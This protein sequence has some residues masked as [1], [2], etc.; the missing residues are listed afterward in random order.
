MKRYYFSKKYEVSKTE[1]VAQIPKG[2]KETF[3]YHSGANYVQVD[4]DK[5]IREDSSLLPAGAQ[6][7][8]SVNVATVSLLG[9]DDTTVFIF[10][11][12]NTKQ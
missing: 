3:V 5:S 4:F 1:V 11:L 6:I 8:I 2:N 7:D 12:T 10:G 9:I